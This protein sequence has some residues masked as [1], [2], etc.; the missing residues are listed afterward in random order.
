[1][2]DPVFEEFQQI[3]SFNPQGPQIG[4]GSG[5]MATF[6]LDNISQSDIDDFNAMKSALFLRAAVVWE[7]DTGIYETDEFQFVDAK[8]RIWQ[9]CA[10]YNSEVKLDRTTQAKR[11]KK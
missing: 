5:R 7:D 3:A 11:F 4:P 10:H 2:A 6:T 8:H 1:M 9:T